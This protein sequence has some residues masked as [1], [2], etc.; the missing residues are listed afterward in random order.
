M[1]GSIDELESLLMQAIAES[2]ASIAES[3]CLQKE[4]A[5]IRNEIISTRE[6]IVKHPAYKQLQDAVSGLVNARCDRVQQNLESE[7]VRYQ[8]LC[9]EVELDAQKRWSDFEAEQNAFAS[10]DLVTKRML[11]LKASIDE[12]LP[13]PRKD[14]GREQVIRSRGLVMA[15]LAG[16]TN[17]G[18][19]SATHDNTEVQV[20]A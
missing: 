2:F 1:T 8:K 14:W 4:R 13:M 18:G 3:K 10:A 16:M 12:M 19:S 9:D 5:A 11:V 20:T 7:R 17:V 6:L 15:A